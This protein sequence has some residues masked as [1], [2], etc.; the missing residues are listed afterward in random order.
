MFF[1]LILDQNKQIRSFA[2]SRNGQNKLGGPWAGDL[3]Q[4]GEDKSLKIT[5][6]SNF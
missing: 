5:L 6:F 1:I 3:L 2:G 4:S